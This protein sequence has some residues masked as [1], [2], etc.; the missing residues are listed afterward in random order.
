MLSDRLRRTMC[1]ALSLIWLW[2]VVHA[3]RAA[4]APPLDPRGVPLVT[5]IGTV[6][7]A[8]QADGAFIVFQGQLHALR[9]QGT[10]NGY[11]NGFFE[12]VNQKT[13]GASPPFAR[14]Y[15]CGQAMVDDG[16]IYVSTTND[17]DRADGQ[18]KIFIHTSKDMVNWQ[19]RQAL[20]LP[21]WFVFKSSTCKAGDRYVMMLETFKA[22]SEGRSV[23]HCRFAT[24]P[25]M[26]QW[27]MTPADCWFDNGDGFAPGHFLRYC[28]GQFYIFYLAIEPGN[29]GW[30]MNVARSSDL[31]R[32]E[33]S[34]LNPVLRASEE[35]RKIANPKLT[36]DQRAWIAKKTDINNSDMYFIE[37]EG[38]VII[39]YFWDDQTADPI[40]RGIGRATYPGTESQ[41]LHG[42]FKE[43][44]NLHLNR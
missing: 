1:V 28:D 30:A 18:N 44:A 24:S 36:A 43:T 8:H 21:G 5:K 14:G 32:W 3:N 35:D 37:H 9:W 6:D 27:T 34:P 11:Q 22:P 2:V 42:W 10:D 40:G 33:K 31:I 17:I 15:G 26:I 29:A 4:A 20:D 25:D 16:T 39:E 7:T 23:A 38:Q 13:G 19:V 41:F 12:F